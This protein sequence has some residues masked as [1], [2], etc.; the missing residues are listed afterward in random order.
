M[1]IESTAFAHADLMGETTARLIVRLICCL[2]ALLLVVG[3]DSF[4]TFSNKMSPCVVQGF[5]SLV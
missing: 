5:L 2:A 4:N 1:D 3:N